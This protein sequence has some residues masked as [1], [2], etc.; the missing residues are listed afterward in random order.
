MKTFLSLLLLVID[1]VVSVHAQV[2]LPGDGSRKRRFEVALDEL[3]EKGLEEKSGWGT[4]R[5]RLGM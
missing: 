4:R 5:K 2:P 1:A 3:S